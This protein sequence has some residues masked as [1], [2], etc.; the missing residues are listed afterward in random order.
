MDPVVL[1]Y[2]FPV[3]LIFAY[4]VVQSRR[5]EARS[6]FV[7]AQA[8]EAGMTEPAS[9]HPVID[10]TRCV[11]CGACVRACP[12]GQILGLVGGR[13]AL[14][15]PSS[16]IGHG[17]CRAACPLDAINLV[18]GTA[19]RGV[20][21]PHVS[22]TFETNVSGIFIAGELGGMGLIRNAVEQGRQAIEAVR[23]RGRARNPGMMDV[24]IIGAGPAGISASL[25]AIERGLSYATLEQDTF[26]GTVAHF[27]RAKLVMT[28]PAKL[29][30]I[31]EMPFRE[32]RKEKLLSFWYEAARKT[33]LLIHESERVEAIEPYG[34]GFQVQTTRGVHFGRSVIL[35]IGRR[36]TPR[37]LGVEGE[38]LEKV[39]YRLVDSEQYRGQRVLVVGGGD[40]ALEAAASLAEVDG[41]QVTLSYRS[42]AFSRS[43]PKNRQRVDNAVN[44][45]SLQLMLSS[46][47]RCIAPDVVE[48]EHDGKSIRLA[49][50]AVIV[51]A[52]GILPTAF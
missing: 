37:R 40:S 3:A 45:G 24:V 42:A 22:E 20:D 14:I 50:D 12:E 49:N 27:P 44:T 31:G 2:A 11:G 7:L 29:P 16:C 23:A 33:G 10:P 38:H 21:I 6:R 30:L 52:G 13:A 47:V 5:T 25:A 8:K 15:E 35:A 28:S 51:C 1:A 43:K 34:E 19:T 32:V 9:L 46:S 26:G 48:L 17:A 36:G 4:Y 41:T 18:F 39:V